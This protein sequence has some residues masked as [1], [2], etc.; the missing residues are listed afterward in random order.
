MK[1]LRGD[2]LDETVRRI[3]QLPDDAKVALP[4]VG[5]VTAREFLSFVRLARAFGL[6]PPESLTRG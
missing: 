2:D 1:V 4:G 3:A 5:N 6:L